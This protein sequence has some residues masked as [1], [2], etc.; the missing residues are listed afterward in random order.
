M[1]SP[2]ANLELSSCQKLKHIH[3]ERLHKDKIFKMWT[4]IK[5]NTFTF[6]FI[7]GCFVA[8]TLAA[9]SEEAEIIEDILKIE[10]D[11]SEDMS[12][13]E[14]V[15]SARFLRWPKP[16]KKIKLRKRLGH[17][18]PQ[19]LGPMKPKKRLHVKTPLFM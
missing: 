1:G 14:S 4:H 16:S 2:Q 6:L 11:S 3:P 12:S 15:R 13:S 18:S 7:F 9:T 19:N 17:P 5:G 10:N 8:F